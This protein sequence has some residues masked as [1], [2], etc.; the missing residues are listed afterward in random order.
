MIFTLSIVLSTSL[1]R[2][3]LNRMN[4]DFLRRETVLVLNKI[5]LDFN[6]SFSTLLCRNELQSN[7]QY[8]TH[9]QSMNRIKFVGN[10]IAHWVR[11]TPLTHHIEKKNPSAHFRHNVAHITNED[12]T[13]TYF[14][15]QIVHCLGFKGVVI[16]GVEPRREYK[17][18]LNESRQLNGPEPHHSRPDYIDQSQIHDL[19]HSGASYRI[20]RTECKSEGRR[21]N[22]STFKDVSTCYD[23]DGYYK[24]L[25]LMQ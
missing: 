3:S 13:V 7:Q 22:D 24:V 17:G 12:F 19:A 25:G 6:E 1:T 20:A 23:K 10:R 9:F 11:E 15:L 2:P 14:A 16:I 18:A 5:H 21:I 4:F 8:F